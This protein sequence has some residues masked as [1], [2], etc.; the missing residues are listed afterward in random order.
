MRLAASIFSLAALVG[1][2]REPVPGDPCKPTLIGCVDPRTELVCQK[3]VFIA[4]PCKGPMGCRDDGKHLFCDVTGN[5]EGDTCSRDE[6]AAAQCIGDKQRITCRGGKYTL[7]FCRG[8]DGCSAKG[9]VRCDQSKGQE[10]DPC[11]GQ[12]N[13]CS[14]DGKRVLVCHGGRFATA[15]QC[16][17]EAG[18]T[19]VDRQVSCDLGK[20]E[21]RDRKRKAGAGAP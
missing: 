13:A 7:D 4:A 17:G 8:D 19:I 3:G 6:E 16:P 14:M 15:A 2:H 5:A 18:C 20:E 9:S 12:A 21:E 11:T 10:D 1:C